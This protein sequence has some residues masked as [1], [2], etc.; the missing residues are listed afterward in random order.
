MRS[1]VVAGRSQSN[2][3][4]TIMGWV[5]LA[6]CTSTLG[7]VMPINAQ[8]PEY[9]L[10]NVIATDSG[11]IGFPAIDATRRRLYGVGNLVIDIDAGR[12]VATLHNSE[13]GFVLA[14]EIGRGLGADGTVFDLN[15]LATID[16]LQTDGYSSVYDSATGRAFLLRRESWVVDM[17]D[18][19][20]VGMVRL[21]AQPQ[22]AVSDGAGRVYVTLGNRDSLA[23][24]DARTL[25][26]VSRWPV[27]SCGMTGGLSIDREHRRLFVPCK[28]TMVVLSSDDGHEVARLRVAHGAFVTAFDPG[29]GL[30][31]NPNGTSGDSTMTVIHE[32]SPDS[33]RIVQSIVTG[34]DGSRIAVV[35]PLTHRVYVIAPRDDLDA[36]EVFAAERQR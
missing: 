30:L 28:R 25:N 11:E 17:R 7:P 24:V 29:T 4:D 33:Y 35:D 5:V 18:H 22:S 1:R 34:A 16:K 36:V 19:R 23:V 14:P 10:V 9:H 2:T 15:S 32:D 12:P 3:R 6:A 13:H 21:E 27:S 26:V 20:I 31:F 8:S